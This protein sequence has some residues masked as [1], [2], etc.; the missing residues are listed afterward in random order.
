MLV[1]NVTLTERL[2][3]LGHPSQLLSASS[4]MREISDPLTWVFCF[5]S[6]IAVKTDHV[7]TKQLVAYA[8]IIIQLFWKHGGVGWRNYD[9]RFRQQLATGALLEWT[10]VEPSILATSVLRASVADSPCCSLCWESDHRTSD[11]ALATWERRSSPQQPKT[12]RTH[13]YL[14]SKESCKKYNNGYCRHV[15]CRYLQVCSVCSGGDHVASA[16]APAQ[17]RHVAMPWR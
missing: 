13:P 2:Q 15:K 8:Q 12:G 4:K 5:L 17:D 3:E 10:H 14:P 9:T 6:L 1:D 7:P 16:C 11:C